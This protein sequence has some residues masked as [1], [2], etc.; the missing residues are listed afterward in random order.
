M[1]IKRMLLGLGLLL[2]LSNGVASVPECTAAEG[3]KFNWVSKWHY[4]IGTI[5]W[6]FGVKKRGLFKN[7]E[8][9]GQGTSTFSSGEKYVGGFRDGQESGQGTMTWP[10]GDKY[11]GSWSDGGRSGK[12]TFTWADGNNYFGEFKDGEM[13]GRGTL[14]FKSGNFKEGVWKDSKFWGTIAE[15]EVVE[16]KRIAKQKQEQLVEKQEQLVRQKKKEKYN[17]IYTACLLDKSSSV[18]MQVFSVESAVKETCKSIATK[19]SWLEKL[20]YD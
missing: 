11:V 13:N 8:L 5:D 17:K 4:C 15:W 12:G 2:V 1:G 18:D 9:N 19:P 20:R 16:K 6:G 14:T 7:G 10:N 3:D